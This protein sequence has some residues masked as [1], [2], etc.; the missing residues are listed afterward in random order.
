MQAIKY[1]FLVLLLK[2]NSTV[3]AQLAEQDTA[4]W[5][6]RTDAGLN[7]SVGNVNRF[8]TRTD[9]QLKHIDTT[10]GLAS[11]HSY[12]YG[13]FGKLLTEND[14]LTKNFIYLF[15]K[16]RFYPYFK[17]WIESNFRRKIDMR[18]QA[19]PGGTWVA[20]RKNGHVLKLST[21]LT[22]ESTAFHPGT[23][24]SDESLSSQKVNVWR[25]I[26]RV[27]GYHPLWNKRIQL[28]YELLYQQSLEKANN[29]R[30]YCDVGLECPLS[31]RLFLRS[32][33]FL[34]HEELTL[35]FLKKTDYYW[36]VGLS[37]HN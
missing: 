13:T 11:V 21:T 1:C 10:W 36:T 28:M 34:S 4:R 18:Y 32:H 14:Y 5:Y 22:Y 16:K 24:L 30:Y 8:F 25:G 7:F 2:L 20:L 3:F 19:G 17:I 9:F 37:F 15:P 31:K 6:Y 29:Y 26:G 23:L 35:K 27:Y 12:M 33:L